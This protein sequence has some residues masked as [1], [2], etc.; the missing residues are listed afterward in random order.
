MYPI[1]LDW[2]SVGLTLEHFEHPERQGI[3]LGVHRQLDQM[4]QDLIIVPFIGVGLSFTSTRSNWVVMGRKIGCQL[5]RS[6]SS[7]KTPSTAS[8]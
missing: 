3:E 8:T 6:L 5:C 2:P 7:R 1:T 4:C